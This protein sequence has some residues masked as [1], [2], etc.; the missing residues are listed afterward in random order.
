MTSEENGDL[1]ALRRDVATLRMEMSQIAQWVAYAD[2]ALMIMI[3]AGKNE[4][5]ETFDKYFEL[6]NEATEEIR[7]IATDAFNGGKDMFEANN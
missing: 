6:F 7:S 1:A 3:L 2:Q 5:S 4:E